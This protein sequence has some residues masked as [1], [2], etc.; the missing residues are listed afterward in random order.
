MAGEWWSSVLERSLHS[1]WTSISANSE[2]AAE[3]GDE[4]EEIWGVVKFES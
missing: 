1:T 3:A 4:D 2:A